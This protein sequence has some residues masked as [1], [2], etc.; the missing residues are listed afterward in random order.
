MIGQ[1]PAF[2]SK[3]FQKGILFVKHLLKAIGLIFYHMPIFNLL[4]GSKSMP[5]NFL[6]WY[7]PSNSCWSLPYNPKGITI[8]SPSQLL[9]RLSSRHKGQAG[10]LVYKKLIQRKAIIPKTSQDKW[11]KDCFIPPDQLIQWQRVY[12]FSFKYTKCTRLITFQSH[13]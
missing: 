9:R 6:A 1:K 8:R 10:R 2:Y 13:A 7:P 11:L 3:C 4:L 12:S 5:S